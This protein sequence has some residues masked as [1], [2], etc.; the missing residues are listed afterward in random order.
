MKARFKR[1]GNIYEILG[2]CKMQDPTPREW[3]DAV[4]YKDQSN[5]TYVREQ[6]DFNNKFERL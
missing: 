6:E 3:L 2:T 4:I 1:T 5:N